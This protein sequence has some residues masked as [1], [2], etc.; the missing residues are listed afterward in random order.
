[1]CVCICVCLCV[2]TH[3][4]MCA[5][6]YNLLSPSNA[7][8]LAVLKS[9][10]WILVNQSEYSSPAQS[11]LLLLAFFSRLYFFMWGWGLMGFSLSTLAYSLEETFHRKQSSILQMFQI[12][13]SLY[14]VTFHLQF[15]PKQVISWS[16]GCCSMG[17]LLLTPSQGTTSPFSLC[18]ASP[19]PSSW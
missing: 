8:C 10:C 15:P 1:M 5:P 7:N 2:C 13:I 9:E 11:H 16:W 14:F 3:V 12:P 18:P 6:K 17:A 19:V 4:H